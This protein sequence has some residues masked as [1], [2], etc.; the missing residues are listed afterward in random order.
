MK[1]IPNLKFTIKLLDADTAP[2][3]S[4]TLIKFTLNQA[5]DQGFDFATMRARSKVADALDKMAPD[6]AVIEM[7]D[8]D[9]A[10]ARGCV[11]SFRWS[12][13]HPDLVKFG[14]LFGL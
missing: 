13:G 5:P 1:S 14:E 6:T 12:V 9:F 11:E 7:E 10:T 8:T 2:A 3:T 4:A